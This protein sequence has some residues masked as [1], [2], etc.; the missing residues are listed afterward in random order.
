M[1][2]DKVAAT[3]RANLQ[4]GN[5][6]EA[7]NWKNDNLE[8]TSSASVA[9]D[10]CN[11]SINSQAQNGTHGSVSL[12]YDGEGDESESKNEFSGAT[13]AIREPRVVVQTTSEVDILDDGYLWRKYGQKVVKGNPNPR[14]YY[15]CTNAGYTV[16][17]HVE[18]VS[19]DL[20]SVI[21]AYQGKAQP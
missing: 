12:G 8:V 18:R 7:A 9:P 19:H 20:K 21:T 6:T 3:E 1:L 13:R 5:V 14:S 17:K 11:Q 2:N 10:Y 4:K 15:K 16:R